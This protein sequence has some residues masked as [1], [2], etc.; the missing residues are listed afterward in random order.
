WGERR[1]A[2]LEKSPV[3]LG[4]ASLPSGAE[5]FAHVRRCALEQDLPVPFDLGEGLPC[6]FTLFEGESAD[7]LYMAAHHI[8]LDGYG[9]A[10]F[11]KRLAAVYTAMVHGTEPEASPYASLDELMGEASPTE[12]E[13][14]LA[15]AYWRTRLGSLPEPPRLAPPA[16]LRRGYVRVLRR[17]PEE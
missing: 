4:R 8:E 17:M 14:R 2:A 7:C 3:T 16:P 6:R 11:L 1:R 10:L 9:Y 12:E 15:A 5:P 13:Q